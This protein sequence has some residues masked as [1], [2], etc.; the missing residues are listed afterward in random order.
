MK[1][2]DIPERNLTCS[3]C[4]RSSRCV[5][6]ILEQI[7]IDFFADAADLGEIWSALFLHMFWSLSAVCRENDRLEVCES[8]LWECLIVRLRPSGKTHL[9][10]AFSLTRKFSGRV[11]NKLSQCMVR[12]LNVDLEMNNWYIAECLAIVKGEVQNFAYRAFP[13]SLDCCS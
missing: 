4:Y 11:E 12:N 6:L 10:G 9:L 5:A 1:T 3:A 2:G 8:R 13:S 7:W